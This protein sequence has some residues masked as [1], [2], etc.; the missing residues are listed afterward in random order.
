MQNSMM[1]FFLFQNGNTLFGQIWSKKIKI[2]SL[3]WNLTPSLIWI[4]RI[5]WWFSLL[6]FLTGNTLLGQVWSKIKLSVSKGWNL[7]PTL[8]WIY[9][10]Q[11]W[12]SL[13]PFSTSNTLFRQILSKTRNCQSKLKFG[14]KTNSNMQNSMMIFA[15]FCLSPEIPFWG[16]LGP[17]N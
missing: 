10:I 11:W 2:V 14:T 5:E 12:C 15:F 7:V 4:C 3:G 1:V 17:K 13:F 9:R 6:P 16:N 8:I